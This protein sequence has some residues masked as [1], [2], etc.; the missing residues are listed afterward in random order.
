MYNK[1]EMIFWPEVPA[2]DTSAPAS[3][4]RTAALTAPGALGG[5]PWK[6]CLGPGMVHEDLLLQEGEKLGSC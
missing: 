2:K 1:G 6:G 5:G 4:F 3:A